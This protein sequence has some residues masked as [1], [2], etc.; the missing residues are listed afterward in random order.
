MTLAIVS[1]STENVT[2]HGDMGEQGDDD[3][4]TKA[5]MHVWKTGNASTSNLQRTLG[6][7]YNAAAR[8]IE[9]MEGLAIISKA[10]HVGK[11]EVRDP[12]ALRSALN[13]REKITDI[14]GE[15]AGTILLKAIV[16][17]LEKVNTERRRA[18]GT[19]PM[20]HDPDFAKQNTDA[21]SVT[22][23]ELRQFV[24][25]VEQLEAE[26]KDIA[27]QIKEVMAEAK[28]RGYDTKILRKV[29]SLRKRKPDELAEED[30]VLEVYKAA[31]GMA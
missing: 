6:L 11:R 13:I 27:E 25:R 2:F 4:F 18:K 28:G 1:D 10:N 16:A 21:Y 26:K 17:D 23:E 14:A 19:P 30:A 24:E 22:A 29:I 7:G 31:L 20:K 3:L 5:V 9:R 15:Q 8:L 12:D